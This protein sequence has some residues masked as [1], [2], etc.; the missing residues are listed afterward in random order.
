MAKGSSSIAA[1]IVRNAALLLCVLLFVGVIASFAIGWT[2]ERLWWLLLPV[3]LCCCLSLIL[4]GGNVGDPISFLV[5]GR[6]AIGD[7]YMAG[8]RPGS[9]GNNDGNKIL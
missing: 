6:T 2:P 1:P 4:I 9:D 7:G 3:G 5:G 8:S